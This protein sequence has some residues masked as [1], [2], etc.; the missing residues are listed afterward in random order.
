MTATADAEGRYRTSAKPGV[1]FGVT[2]YPPAGVPYLVRT[3]PLSQPIRWTPGQRVKRVNLALPRGILVRGRILEA[4]SHKP[5]AGAAVQYV[6][7]R[8]NNPHVS[9]DILTGWQ[10]IGVSDRDGRFRSAVLPGPGRLLVHGPDERYVL[11]EIGSREVDRGRP[12]GRRMYAHAIRKIEPAADAESIDVTI[13]LQR[14]ATIR[15]RVVD[16]QGNPI[17][18]VLVISRLNISPLSL[19]WRGH[20]APTLGGRFELGGLEEGRQYTVHFLD[21]TRRLGATAR[22]TA[23][24]PELTVVLRP[25]G[26]AKMRFVDADGQPLAGYEPTVRMVV[27]PGPTP[28][29]R[30]ALRAG[31]LQAD[32]DFISNIDRANHG[33]RL[34]SDGHGNLT[35][36]ALIPGAVYRVLVHRDKRFHIAREFQVEPGQTVDLGN[37]LADRPPLR[38]EHGPP[39]PPASSSSTSDKNRSSAEKVFALAASAV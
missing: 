4:G 26:E 16:E 29:D 5:V 33:R 27:T 13:E 11:R 15:G 3:T 39:S 38:F 31:A 12:G 21:P 36:A 22:V 20:T 8:A 18:E 19:F 6:P 28:Y 34:K 9:E 24:S 17:D 14:G 32:S 1:C 35:V 37:I 2:A 25:C 10:T 23:A 30:G 7:E